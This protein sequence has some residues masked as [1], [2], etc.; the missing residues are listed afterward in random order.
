MGTAVLT[1]REAALRKAPIR[2]E[3]E[4]IEKDEK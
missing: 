1:A 2:V 4:G 3:K